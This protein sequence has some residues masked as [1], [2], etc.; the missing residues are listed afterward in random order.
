MRL[1][2]AR[3]WIV[4]PAIVAALGAF[5]CGGSKT[6]VGPSTGE[7]SGSGGSGSGGNNSGGSGS[8]SSGSGQ[9]TIGITDTPFSDAKAVL[10]TFDS[11]S[12][13]RSGQGWETVAF[14]NGATERT[15]DLK[16]LQGPTDVLGSDLLPA[17]HYTQVRLQVKAATIH[18]DNASTS[19]TACAPSI[20]V[21]GTQFANV[22]VASG[23]VKLN[24]EFTLDAGA[25]VTMV[26][27][28]D[29]DKSIRQQGGG[30]NGGGNGN[31]NG[32][33]NGGGTSAP[34]NGSYSLQP[35]VSIV[36]VT[37]Q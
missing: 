22:K 30:G 23:E 24:R 1:H 11:I 17:G 27:D 3:S 34:E 18:F 33:G 16:K 20:T 36:S 35:V 4:I 9:L 2:I 21:P 19:T 29:G 5:G 7:S 14:A 28:F 26:L 37:G 15:C 31:G 13:H 25:T 10:I 12:V 6:P 8:T 32:N